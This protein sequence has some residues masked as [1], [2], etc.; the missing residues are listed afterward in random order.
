MVE[1]TL[2]DVLRL[3]RAKPLADLLSIHRT[4]GGEVYD[5][6]AMQ[7]VVDLCCQ[8]WLGLIGPAAQA[9]RFL[10]NPAPDNLRRVRVPKCASALLM[11]GQ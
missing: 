2:T 1:M 5:F 6:A 10:P 3:F 4:Q 8:R 9:I 11:E 7:P